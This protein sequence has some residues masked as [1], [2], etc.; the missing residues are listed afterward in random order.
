M[1]KIKPEKD[2]CTIDMSEMTV[3]SLDLRDGN[4]VSGIIIDSTVDDAIADGS[5]IYDIRH[6]DDTLNLAT[7]EK[8]VIVNKECSILLEEPLE[9]V[10]NGDCLEIADWGYSDIETAMSERLANI[11]GE[12][13]SYGWS[14]RTWKFKDIADEFRQWFGE[15]LKRTDR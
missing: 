6:S 11:I 4:T 9:A 1:D 3:L 13:I 5:Y 2:I 10:E 15:Y 14:R 12:F 8:E 7:I